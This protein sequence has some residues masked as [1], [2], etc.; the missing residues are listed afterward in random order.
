MLDHADHTQTATVP[1]MTTHR[2]R[3]NQPHLWLALIAG[4]L[5]LPG[6]LARP[7]LDAAIQA[8]LVE[9]VTAA[10]EL[11]AYHARCRSD[12]SG[13]RTENLNKLIVSKLRLTILSVQ[14]DFF[15]E[16]S[17]RRTQERLERDFIEQLQAVGGCAGAK[18]SPLPDTLRQRYDTALEA[19]RRLP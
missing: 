16:R 15:P 19:I 2:P 10:V 9:A 3:M 14:D 5:T 6:A 7:E 18:T 4:L 17:Y 13:R 12:G 1:T 11:D 8:Q